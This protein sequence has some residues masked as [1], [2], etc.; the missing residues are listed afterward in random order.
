MLTCELEE[1]AGGGVGLNVYN[2]AMFVNDVHFANAEASE[3][4]LVIGSAEVLGAVNVTDGNAILGDGDYTVEDGVFRL[5]TNTCSRSKAIIVH[6]QS[7]DGGAEPV[8][9]GRNFLQRRLGHAVRILLSHRRGADFYGRQGHGGAARPHRRDGSRLLAG[10][11]AGHD[12]RGGVGGV[13]HGSAVSHRLYR[14]RQGGGADRPRRARPHRT[15]S[16]QDG[17]H[18]A[19]CLRSRPA[20]GQRRRVFRSCGA[21]KEGRGSL[22]AVSAGKRN[23][24]QWYARPAARRGARTA[25]RSVHRRSHT[26]TRFLRRKGCVFPFGVL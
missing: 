18:R 23:R 22:R 19:A 14:E 6:D 12:R 16:L 20:R 5:T 7:D 11:A 9:C 4:A 2:G 8:F 3:N 15:E 10:R 21:Q 25:F 26:F 17:Q 13:A 1:Y 24:R